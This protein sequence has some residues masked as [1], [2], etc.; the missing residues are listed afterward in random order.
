VGRRRIPEHRVNDAIRMRIR[1]RIEQPGEITKTIAVAVKGDKNLE[2]RR[3]ACRSPTQQD[4][5]LID[6][7]RSRGGGDPTLAVQ[8]DDL[9]HSTQSD[10]LLSLVMTVSVPIGR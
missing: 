3:L 4:R 10:V 1:K 5:G 9:R 8:A 2:G 7:R 6:T